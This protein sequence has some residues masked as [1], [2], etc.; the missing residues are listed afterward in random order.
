[1]TQLY[2]WLSS[3]TTKQS[4]IYGL[5][6]SIIIEIITILFRFGLGLESNNNT[7]FLSKFTFGYRIHHGYIGLLFILTSP[8]FSSGFWKNIFLIAGSGLF[9]SDIAHHFIV[10]WIIKG[11]P[12]FY[13]KY[14]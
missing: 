7:S 13:I 6:L 8:I 3:L 4:F 1:M 9:I 12:E 11:S 14:F 5:L 10:L 2:T